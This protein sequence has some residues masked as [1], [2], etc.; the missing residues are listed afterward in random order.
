[1]FVFSALG[2]LVAP[3]SDHANAGAAAGASGYQPG[4]RGGPS[5]KAGDESNDA[6][7]AAAAITEALGLERAQGIALM[8][9]L[10]GG[11]A[12]HNWTMIDPGLGTPTTWGRWGPGDL[13][14]NHFYADGRGLNSVQILAWL[15]ATALFT[16]NTTYNDLA[17]SLKNQDGYGLR[18]TRKSPRP[19]TTISATTSCSLCPC[20]T[21]W[22]LRMP[23]IWTLKCCAA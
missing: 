5:G 22:C 8:N 3:S 15:R 2:A 4:L 9:D 13:N 11:I 14:D 18:S 21:I 7:A 6:A 17:D 12:S 16:G 20:T 10:I 23:P 19:T 1:M